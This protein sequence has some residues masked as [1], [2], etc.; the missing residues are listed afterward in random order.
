MNINITIIFQVL[1][2]FCAYYFLYRFLFIPAFQILHEQQQVKD[3]LYK[4][5]EHEQQIKDAFLQ[6]Y[7]VKNSAFKDEL[8]YNI[9]VQ[10]IDSVYQKSTFHE[11]LQ[12]DMNDPLSETQFQEIE[13]FLVDH[14]SKVIK[15]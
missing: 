8:V 2:F 3:E 6:D 12:H 9:P 10:D 5:L 4:K 7:R 1:Q 11:I 13:T 15:K 14:L